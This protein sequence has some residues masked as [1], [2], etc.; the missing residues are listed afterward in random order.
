MP[1]QLNLVLFYRNL[2]VCATKLLC[3]TRSSPFIR[4]LPLEFP[5]TIVTTPSVKDPDTLLEEHVFFRTRLLMTCKVSAQHS[6][7]KLEK[8]L[9]DFVKSN[10]CLL[11]LTANMQEVTKK[12]VN[13]LR[14][15]VE[16]AESRIKNTSKLF[17]LLLHFPPAMFFNPCYSSIFLQGWDHYY[18][19]SITPATLTKGADTRTVVDIN[20]WFQQCCCSG[21]KP[22]QH[23]DPILT[24]LMCMLE[25][26]VPVIASRL[27][28]K[29]DSFHGPINGS[30]R[31]GI[32][33]DLLM[34]KVGTAL[35]RR[36]TEYWNPRTMLEL[37]QKVTHFTH[38]QKST[39][40]ITDAIQTT[41]KSF[42]FDFLVYML[43]KINEDHN[44]SIILED[45]TPTTLE[46]FLNLLQTVPVPD[47]KSLQVLSATVRTPQGSDYLPKFPFFKYVCETVDKYISESMEKVNQKTWPSL[48]Q[49]TVDQQDTETSTTPA[50][51]SP[52]SSTIHEHRKSKQSMEGLYFE[53]V[54]SQIKVWC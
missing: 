23:D 21:Y 36:F 53:A 19:D 7:S 14:M 3:F 9:D 12:M 1:G 47:L 33:K 31:T 54:K 13:H 29:D 32:I 15:I 20:E 37:L 45:C 42:F 28:L 27:V 40:N 39:L 52:F 4:Q 8:L 10:C 38:I 5:R 17:V 26:A 41:F 50:K 2:S 46:L 35:S 11:L 30:Q 51:H 34:N 6:Q 43:T 25:D 16:E 18:L 22:R 48:L 24:A 44:L 49:E